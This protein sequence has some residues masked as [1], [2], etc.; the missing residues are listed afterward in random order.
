MIVNC[1]NI[2]LITIKKIIKITNN[3]ISYIHLIHIQYKQNNKNVIKN[4]SCVYIDA[5]IIE[6]FLLLIYK[7]KLSYSYL[8]FSHSNSTWVHESIGN[9]HRRD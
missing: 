9:G 7:L 1:I 5:T 2:E 6:K 3:V 4:T 8:S